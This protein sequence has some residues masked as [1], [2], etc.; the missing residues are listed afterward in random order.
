[1]GYDGTMSRR[2]RWISL[3]LMLLLFG[4]VGAYLLQGSPEVAEEEPVDDGPDWERWVL[5]DESPSDGEGSGP[6]PASPGVDPP[7]PPPDRWEERRE[8]WRERWRQR[9]EIVSLGPSSPTLDPD[10]IR[11]ALAPGRDALRACIRE[12]GGWRALR[13]ADRPPRPEPAAEG[14]TADGEDAPRRRRRRQRRSVSFDV[15]PDGTVDPESV[16]LEPPMPAEL[17]G[18]FRTYFSSAQLDGAGADGAR[19]ELPMAGG[20]GRR[21]RNR[22][23]GDAGIGRR[24]ARGRGEGRRGEGRRGEGA[25]GR[26]G[27]D[28]EGSA[29][30]E[31]PSG[32]SRAR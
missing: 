13:R 25:G 5:L 12:G 8:R 29:W 21:R 16:V 6:P 17:D 26:R 4:A 22:S 11:E 9:V 31:R 14:E 7:A 27:R 3:V 10:S 1:M 32:E 18:C 24:E 23:A 2:A 19:V 28:D 30:D 20:R 15:G